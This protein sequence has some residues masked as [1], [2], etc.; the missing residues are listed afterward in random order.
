MKVFTNYLKNHIW[1]SGIALTAKFLGALTDLWIPII[2]ATIIDEIAVQEDIPLTLK[3]GGYMLLVAFAS[4]VFNFTANFLASVIAGRVGQAVRRDLFGKIMYLSAAQVDEITLS[5]LE[6]RLT[7]DTYNIQQ[8][9]AMMLRMGVRAP[10][11]LVG[12]ICM[13]FFLDPVL[14]IIITLVMP[15]IIIFVMIIAKRGLTLYKNV[16]AGEDAMASCVRENVLGIRVIK[17]LAAKDFETQ[18]FRDIN[19]NLTDSDIKATANMVLSNPFANG[20]LNIGS[21]LIVLVGGYRVA[22]GACDVGVLLAFA[23]YFTIISAALMSISRIFIMTTKGLASGN[24]IQEVLDREEDLVIEKEEKRDD[25]PYIYFDHVNFSYHVRKN[26]KQE[27]NLKNITIGLEKGQTLGVLGA[28]GS[29]KSTLLLLLMRFYDVTDGNIYIDGE[30]IKGIPLETLHKK[31]GVTLQSD[32][33][34]SDSILENICF[35]RDLE[36]EDVEK[37]LHV[38]QAEKFVNSYDETYD[39]KLAIKGSNLSGGQKQRLLIA[40]AVAGSP[41]ILILDD[42]SS[43][44]DYKTDSLLRKELQKVQHKTTTVLVAQRI[45][46]I[47]DADIIVIL[48]KG[49]IVDMGKHEELM[50]RCTLYQDLSAHQLGS[51]GE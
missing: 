22:A 6:T 38:A 20:V 16:Q 21:V 19:Q 18:K 32:Y 13:S 31:F 44:L 8:V 12:G 17:A 40:R 51:M 41:D 49:E 30:N 24:R 34:F 35:G 43:A 48:D 7:S 45:S 50:D 47:K 39:Y 27:M 1:K 15:I 37:S 29:G 4:L 23:T 33:L 9:I 14:A 10:V 3:W 25:V 46:S 28:T 5:S 2:L 11:L 42:S 36:M 26:A